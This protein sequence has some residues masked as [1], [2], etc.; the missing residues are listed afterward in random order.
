MLFDKK[1]KPGDYVIEKEGANTILKINYDGYP[2]LPS[3]EDS[4]FTMARVIDILVE[5]PGVN[6]IL[7]TQRR[8]Y[9]YSYEQTNI[10]SEIAGV[11]S[12]LTKQKK[13]LSLSFFE[14]T[15]TF[16]FYAQ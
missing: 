2:S 13:I 3:V 14:Q 4:E 16:Q 15:A 6:T 9:V 1:V 8:N 7:F 12:Y 11:Y 10:L 5:S